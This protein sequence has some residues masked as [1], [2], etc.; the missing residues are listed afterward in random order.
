[1]ILSRTAA[2]AL[3]ALT[4][5]GPGCAWWLREPRPAPEPAPEAHP[6]RVRC[7]W[8]TTA[9]GPE[10]GQAVAAVATE[11]ETS[12]W[13][14]A[15]DSAGRRIVVAGD[16]EDG[17]LRADGV[18]AETAAEP[19]SSS[20]L[21]LAVKTVVDAC[22]DTL[23]RR[24]PPA[25]DALYAVVAARE[26]EGRNVAIA[27]PPPPGGPP[28]TRMVVFG[29]SLSDQ[30]NLKRR[31]LIFPGSPYWLGRFADG[32][33]W[34]DWLPRTTGLAVQN[35]SF[36]GAIAVPHDDVPAD[37]LVAAVQQGAQ[38]IVSGSVDHYVGDHIAHDLRDGRVERPESTVYVFWA[39]A[40]DYIS[41]EPF[42]GDIGT[43]LDAPR[44]Q[45]GYMRVVRE[46]VDSIANQV[47]RLYAAG[48]RHFLVITL[49]D[50]GESPVVLHNQSYQPKGVRDEQARR[51]LLSRRLSTLVRYHNLQLAKATAALVRELPGATVILVD[52]ERLVEGMMGKSSG[53]GRSAAFDYGFELR[54]RE[55]RV[56]DTK[57][58][59]TVQDRCYRGGYLGSLDP[60][61]VCPDVARVFFWD[62]VHPTSY[63][64]CWIA[65]SFAEELA[66]KGWVAQ[67]P[68]K[69]DQ[70]LYCESVRP[71]ARP[72]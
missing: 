4:V 71:A 7:G 2:A 39:G 63:A 65:W 53:R 9:P 51:G 21:P 42:S 41:K 29:D 27:F 22:L 3:L 16:L 58:G 50:I 64:H 32:P 46:T 48:A 62:T 40:N 15:S 72:D 49:P 43:L 69:Q 28:I 44:G 54:S 59:R 11:V 25:P 19:P 70:R 12:G 24:T 6:W 66:A 1:M 30:G 37:D 55:Q 67:P 36:G 26:D 56:G 13:V 45:A 35:H 20:A 52:A 68:P 5:L 38:H 60:E 61:A 17:F 47:R 18:L 33:V 34:T 10:P 23:R 31:L 14:F 8:A 57:Q